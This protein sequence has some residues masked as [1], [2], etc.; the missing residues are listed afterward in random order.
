MFGELV[1]V[2]TLP[3]P[4]ELLSAAPEMR[5]HRAVPIDYLD[6]LVPADQPYLTIQFEYGPKHPGAERPSSSAA[7]RD[8]FREDRTPFGAKNSAWLGVSE[9]I[10]PAVR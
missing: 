4:S 7:G 9:L 6:E 2:L 8:V 5:D 10:H 1:D 3:R